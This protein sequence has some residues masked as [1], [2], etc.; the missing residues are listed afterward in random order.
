MSTA[1]ASNNLWD[2]F[3]PHDVIDMAYA[4]VANGRLCC[5]EDEVE[6]LLFCEEEE[7]ED[8]NSVV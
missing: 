1:A 2:N 5:V 8:D 6:L 4:T 7:K 3:G